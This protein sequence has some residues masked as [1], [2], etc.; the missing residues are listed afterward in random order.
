M[1]FTYGNDY[2]ITEKTFLT[3]RSRICLPGDL[4]FFSLHS[5][6]IQAGRK[7]VAAA[8]AFMKLAMG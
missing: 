8:V 7:V 4:I 3:F 6:G 1:T 5:L 2:H